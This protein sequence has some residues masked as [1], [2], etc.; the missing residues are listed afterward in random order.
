MTI[1]HLINKERKSPISLDLRGSNGGVPFDDLPEM[2]GF[3][4]ILAFEET[5]ELQVS[6]FSELLYR[7][8][9]QLTGDEQEF[10]YRYPIYRIGIDLAKDALKAYVWSTG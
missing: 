6:E 10:N 5:I 4:R 7:R 8:T 1:I 2:Q 9:G 3:P